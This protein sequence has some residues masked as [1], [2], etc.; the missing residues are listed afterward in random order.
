MV[1]FVL[2]TVAFFAAVYW[3]KRY[4]DEQD[5]SH[6]M[7]RNMVVLVLATAVSLMVSAA[8]D[9][10]DDQPAAPQSDVRQVIKLLGQ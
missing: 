8:V 5:I 4:L 9:S 6:G 1:S 10:V 7:T 3:A 2:S